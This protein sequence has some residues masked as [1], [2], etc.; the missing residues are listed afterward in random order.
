MLFLQ[1]TKEAEAWLQ[2]NGYTKS[3]IYHSFVRHWNKL[4]KN[5][6]ND[7]EYSKQSMADYCIRLFG[8]NLMEEMPSDLSLKEY[9]ISH[10]LRSLVEFMSLV[11][12]PGLL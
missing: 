7:S 10:A 11:L 1:L 9:R 4:R 6:G 3:T 12:F 5:L 2:K 8:K